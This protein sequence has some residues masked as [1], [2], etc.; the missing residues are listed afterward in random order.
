M[1]DQ[2]VLSIPVEESVET[3]KERVRFAL[4]KIG[5]MLVSE[6]GSLFQYNFGSPTLFRLVGKIGAING[7]IPLKL[8]I[9][10]V[11]GEG[12]AVVEATINERFGFWLGKKWLEAAYGK[13]CE[14]LIVMLKY[15]VSGDVEAYQGMNFAELNYIK[16]M[17]ADQ[18]ALFISEMGKCKKEPK[19]G[20]WLSLLLGT[21]GAHH[22]YLKKTFLGVVYVVFCWTW[23]PT[24]LGI[25]ESIFMFKRVEVYNLNCAQEVAMRVKVLS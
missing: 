16:K 25:V 14:E 11:G 22:F 4:P 9:S 21:F 5:G 20:F 6:S 12:G 17:T 13:A 3:I 10:I 23:I 2:K 7:L 24:T 19:V 1:L 8:D 18:K 15:I